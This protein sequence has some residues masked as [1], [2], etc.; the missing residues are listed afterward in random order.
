MRLRN[1]S[2][3]DDES[4]PCGSG[5]KFQECCKGRTSSI[6]TSKKPPEVQV[7]EKMR[8]SMKKC[9]L[10]PEKEKC[11]GKIK[12]AHA[13]Q[14]NKI[15][16]M[17]A[18]N[19]H[20]V[21]MLDAKRQPV[22]VPL[23]NGEVV[24]FV[25]ISKISA[26][27]AT[28]ETCFCDYH[29]NVVFA[30]I[31]KG[32]PDFDNTNEEMKFIYA[33]KAFIFEYYKQWTAL[34]IFRESFKANPVAF[35]D[36]KSIDIYRMLQLK[37]K[38]FEPIKNFFDVR[39][40]SGEY[41]GLYTCA[42]RIPEQINFA[43]YAYIA[44]DYD[45]NGKKIRH[46]KKGVMH[47]LA[48]TIFPEE[49]CSWLLLSCLESEKKIYKKLFSQ[50]QEASIEKMKYYINLVLPL[51]SENMVLSPRIWNEWDEE[52]KMAYT[53]YANL[54]GNDAKVMCMGVGFGLTNAYSDKSGSAYRVQP[55][56]NLFV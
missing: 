47:R 21:Y 41:D 36:M 33:Y 20:H 6:N 53:Y 34:D 49:D 38:E 19:E 45:M 23:D 1:L 4:C 11:R 39:I 46:T 54:N 5:K 30:A 48:I 31:E 24:P 25:E 18:G 29:D 51:Y 17:L 8:A 50:M 10:H 14:N 9:C 42:V 15:I 56:I 37:M 52:T 3:K 27:A 55:N 43:D 40:K 35:E 26:N 13:L 7:M 16:S 28:T 44:P 2:I 22:L 12:S 32:A